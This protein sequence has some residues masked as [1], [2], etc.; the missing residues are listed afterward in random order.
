MGTFG[1]VQLTRQ[2]QLL[3]GPVSSST[4]PPLSH[5][6]WAFSEAG[7]T[8]LWPS[9]L[10]WSAYRLANVTGS[11]RSSRGRVTELPPPVPARTAPPT[12]TTIGRAAM[13]LMMNRR[14][15]STSGDVAAAHDEESGGQ[16]DQAPAGARDDRVHERAGEPGLGEQAVPGLERCREQVRAQRLDASERADQLHDETQ[17][18]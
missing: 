18:D 14:M 9:S 4:A 1:S 13:A 17:D 3:P 12:A 5:M 7:V 16:A 8:P 15:G 11:D 10:A 2:F 6:A